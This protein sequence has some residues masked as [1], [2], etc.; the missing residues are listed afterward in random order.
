MHI[1]AGRQ[2]G[3]KA[4]IRPHD[5]LH[6]IGAEIDLKSIS[7]QRLSA[8]RGRNFGQEYTQRLREGR[9]LF[10]VFDFL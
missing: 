2:A 10:R 5:C 9:K 7:N 3:R 4:D 1:P 8:A 6:L